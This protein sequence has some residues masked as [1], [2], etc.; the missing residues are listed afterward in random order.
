MRGITPTSATAALLSPAPCCRALSGLMAARKG[1]GERSDGNF[2]AILTPYS[3]Q[4][5]LINSLLRR[6]KGSEQ[7]C[8]SWTCQSMTPRQPAANDVCLAYSSQAAGDPTAPCS[9]GVSRS[10]V[11]CRN[12]A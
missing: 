8:Q 10:G 5:R 2:A 9:P 7:V 4:L 12:Q 1:S 6:V 3:A 11:G